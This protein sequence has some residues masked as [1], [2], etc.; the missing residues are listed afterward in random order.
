MTV[1]P[2]YLMGAVFSYPAFRPLEQTD[3][4]RELIESTHEQADSLHE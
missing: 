4:S 2:P 1:P 3:S